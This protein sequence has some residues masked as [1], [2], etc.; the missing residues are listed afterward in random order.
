MLE[1]SVYS[2]ISPR[3]CASILWKN[4]EAEQTAAE[5]LRMTAHDL[6]NMGICDEIIPEAVGGAH[7][8]LATTARNVEA[9]LL[10]HLD[11]LAAMSVETRLEARYAKFRAIGH[12]ERRQH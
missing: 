7:R 1:H 8:G 6:H 9:A 5:Q 10:R 11:E 4:A 3:G 2:V 12:L